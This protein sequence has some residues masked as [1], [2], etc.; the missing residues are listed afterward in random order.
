ML[1]TC[2]HA[3]SRLFLAHGAVLSARWLRCNFYL[4][5][6]LCTLYPAQAV[7]TLAAFMRTF[8]TYMK[9]LW[10]FISAHGSSS[11]LRADSYQD[12]ISPSSRPILRTALS[13]LVIWTIWSLYLPT[14]R[15]FDLYAHS[16]SAYA[17]FR[18]L[19]WPSFQC[20]FSWQISSPNLEVED[21]GQN[22]EKCRS[23]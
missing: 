1:A 17:S 23:R 5:Y 13:T 11:S 21:E 7:H 4:A 12:F 15:C 18:H 8:M 9:P 10:R 16:S 19:I 14:K 6:D 3:L 22:I 20:S 2:Y